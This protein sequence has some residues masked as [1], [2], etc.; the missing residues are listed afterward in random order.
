MLEGL[1]R[2]TAGLRADYE[3]EKEPLE[4]ASKRLALVDDDGERVAIVTAT[5]VERTKFS[6]VPQGFAEAESEGE[7]SI[8][9]WREGHLKFWSSVGER[10]ENETEV[11]LVWF[12][13]LEGVEPLAVDVDGPF[14]TPLHVEVNQHLHFYDGRS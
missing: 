8:E 11:V 9:E 14:L 3:R 5:K 6:E 4:Y 2:A 13:L 7:S 10:I 12:E 1:K